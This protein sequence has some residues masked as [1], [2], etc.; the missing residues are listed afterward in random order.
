M[1]QHRS[2]HNKDRTRVRGSAKVK[3]S[4]KKFSAPKK[5]RGRKPSPKGP[6]QEEKMNVILPPSPPQSRRGSGE[7]TVKHPIILPQPVNYHHFPSP[8]MDDMAYP[9][10]S[11]PQVCYQP[12]PANRD[13]AQYHEKLPCRKLSI[14]S[15][16]AVYLLEHPEK[17]PED[18]KDPPTG[19]LSVRD[20]CHNAGE[21]DAGAALV[22]LSNH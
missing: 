2:T 11:A 13:T 17:S 7:F 5:K 19:R 14:L 1:M 22:M 12:Y 4:N 10:R 16:L 15:Q 21:E 20:M 9:R 18:F 8:E 3:N 6:K